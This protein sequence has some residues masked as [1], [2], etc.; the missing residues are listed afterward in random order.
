M[1]NTYELH[2]FDLTYEIY[3]KAGT[4]ASNNSLAIQ[5]YDATDKCPFATITTNLPA[6][7]SCKKDCAF[8]DLNNCP[9]LPD[10]LE[11]SGLAQPTGRITFSGSYGC[12]Y[13]EYKFDLSKMGKIK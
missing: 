11:N 1:K 12:M 6:S 10:F 3:L 9:W 2:F 8:I 5:S 13:P 4:Y 7:D